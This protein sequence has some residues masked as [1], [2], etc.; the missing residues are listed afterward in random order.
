MNYPYDVHSWSKQYREE[1]L[2]EAQV[3]HLAEQAHGNLR[4]RSWLGRVGFVLSAAPH[5]R[6]G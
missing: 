4:L 3:R 5:G 6:K 2:R 1:A